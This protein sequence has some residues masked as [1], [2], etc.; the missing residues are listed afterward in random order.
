MRPF[1]WQNKYVLVKKCCH[2]VKFILGIFQLFLRVGDPLHSDNDALVRH[3]AGLSAVGAN[4]VYLIRQPPGFDLITEFSEYFGYSRL[5]PA[6]F[7]QNTGH[8][9]LQLQGLCLIR[10]A[11]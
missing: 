4:Q 10:Q 5:Y 2:L 9:D 8:S 11:V 1:F 7:D 3:R 6:N